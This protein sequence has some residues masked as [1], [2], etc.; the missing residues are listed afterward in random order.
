MGLETVDNIF[1]ELLREADEP[2]KSAPSMFP[3]K[4]MCSNGIEMLSM[5]AP[6]MPLGANLH[7]PKILRCMPGLLGR[8]NF[9]K[10]TVPAT[11]SYYS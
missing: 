8:R 1:A 4:T 11:G 3:G 5:K 7:F 2:L 10:F 6:M 9:R